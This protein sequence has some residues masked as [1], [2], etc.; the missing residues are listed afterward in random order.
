MHM[1]HDGRRAHRAKLKKES[2]KKKCGKKNCDAS[3]SRNADNSDESG[4]PSPTPDTEGKREVEHQLPEFVQGSS[5]SGN[6]SQVAAEKSGEHRNK[7][8]DNGNIEDDVDGD[9]KD[10][11]A[12]DVEGDDAGD[13]TGDDDD[14]E[15]DDEDAEAD[16]NGFAKEGSGDQE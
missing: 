1:V 16:G 2:A 6:T 3:Q 7:T 10:E 14:D 13:V 5:C 8:G 11:H 15:D 12:G 4:A 9:V